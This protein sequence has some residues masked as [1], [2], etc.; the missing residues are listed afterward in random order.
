MRYRR[1]LQR[2]QALRLFFPFSF[3][4]FFGASTSS[5]TS[6]AIGASILLMLFFD[7]FSC[8]ATLSDEIFNSSTDA[9]ASSFAAAASR[10]CSFPA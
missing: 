3:F 4:T 7:F 6:T 2:H 5:A 9:S 10:F 8:F 1:Q